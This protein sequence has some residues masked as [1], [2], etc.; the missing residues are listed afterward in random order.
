MNV[1]WSSFDSNI[2]NAVLL[3]FGNT[4]EATTVMIET[5]LI[6]GPDRR[7]QSE[8]VEKQ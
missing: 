4:S 3:F 8:I 6:F 5:G 2:T 7:S 1:S